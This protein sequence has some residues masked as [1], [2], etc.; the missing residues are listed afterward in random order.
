MERIRLKCPVCSAVLE[1]KDDPANLGK[2]IICPNCKQKNKF[3][4]FKRIVPKQIPIAPED[5]HTQLS[6]VPKS[7]VGY[8]LD[9]ATG[10]RY[11]LKEGKQ[12]IGRKP[13]K[14]VSKADIPISTADQG[15]S[16]EHLCLQ[17]ITGQDGHY[18]V[19]ASNAKNKNATEINGV[20]LENG[21]SIGIR[22]GDVIKLCDTRL[23]YIGTPVNDETEL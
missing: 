13:L 14:S 4:S 22:H 8:L 21:D 3:E 1:A 18:H 2:N 23:V 7:P 20:K 17:V 16:R 10:L 15:M 11:P 12:I 19:F 9:K 6:V 5:D